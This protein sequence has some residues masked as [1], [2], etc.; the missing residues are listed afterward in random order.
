M[1]VGISLGHT[2]TGF[3]ILQIGPLIPTIFK[4]Y[5]LLKNQSPF[6]LNLLFAGFQFGTRQGAL[7]IWTA[8]CRIPGILSAKSLEP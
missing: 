3:L 8:Q 4:D 7:N 6:R 2:T 5:I 1:S